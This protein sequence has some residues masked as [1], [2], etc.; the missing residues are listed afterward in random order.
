MSAIAG[1]PPNVDADDFIRKIAAAL[2]VYIQ[3]TTAF[4]A[5]PDRDRVVMAQFVMSDESQF[6]VQ[7]TRL[8]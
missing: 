2:E 8:K 4:G 6:L 1:R 3:H 5:Y 7:V